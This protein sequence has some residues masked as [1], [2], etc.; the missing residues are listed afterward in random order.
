MT[1]ETKWTRLCPSCS[2]QLFHK[3]QESL[4]K[5]LNDNTLC[6]SCCQLP[7]ERR[8][9]NAPKVGEKFC[10]KCLKT[11]LITDFYNSTK[12]AD[13]KQKHC[14]ECQNHYKLECDRENPDRVGET[15]KRHRDKD[16]IAFNEY[17]RDWKRQRTAAGLLVID[18]RYRIRKTCD[19]TIDQE[20][21]ILNWSGGNCPIC[22]VY[23]EKRGSGGS[24]AN[25][26]HDH[27]TNKFRGL[28]CG[29]C[30]WMLGSAKDNEQTLLNAVE[31]L[32]RHKNA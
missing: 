10:T 6:R 21:W 28:I 17:H 13:G 19:M 26:D 11:K 31:Y 7:P 5:S 4:H 14:K 1:E 16:P 30:N 15:R 20:D 22:G 25:I 9:L 12:T 27:A 29:A 24:M 18:K 32:R 3:S 23:M 2:K 8:G